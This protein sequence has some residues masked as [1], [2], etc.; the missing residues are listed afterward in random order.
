MSKS[1]SLKNMIYTVNNSNHDTKLLPN[2]SR[3]EGLKRSR[4]PKGQCPTETEKKLK[5]SNSDALARADKST[6]S[7]KNGLAC[8]SSSLCHDLVDVKGLETSDNSLKTSS[9]SAQRSFLTGEKKRVLNMRHC[10]ECSTVVPAISKKHSSTAVQSERPCLRDSS[11]FASGV[12]VPSWISVVPQL[13]SIW[14]YGF[15]CLSYCSF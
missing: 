12:H 4:H 5:L 7:V 3:V 11:I 14:Q 13:D 10:V 6:A 8:P 9:N 1:T 2:S 15:Y